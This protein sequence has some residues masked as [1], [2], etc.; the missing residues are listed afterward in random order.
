VRGYRDFDVVGYVIHG[1]AYCRDC[2]DL[3]G[4]TE[5]VNDEDIGPVFAGSEYASKVQCE[6]CT[7]P[8]I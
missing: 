2:F 6:D 1:A 3:G 8:L 5:D 4:T 7:E